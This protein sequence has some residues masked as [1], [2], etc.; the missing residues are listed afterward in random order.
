M[1]MQIGE[2]GTFVYSGNR[3]TLSLGEAGNRDTYTFAA[4]LA[5]DELTLKYI[6]STEQGSAK[7][8]T[9]HHRYTLAFYCSSPFEYQQ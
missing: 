5:D 1:A 2:S 7:D 3:L 8:K 4:N 6:G 9:K